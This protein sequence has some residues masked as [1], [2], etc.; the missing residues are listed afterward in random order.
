M[1]VYTEYTTRQVNGTILLVVHVELKQDSLPYS[2]NAIHAI[3]AIHP[4]TYCSADGRM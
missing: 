4:P 2:I 1:C 3:H